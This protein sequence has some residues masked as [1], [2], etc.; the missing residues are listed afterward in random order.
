[1]NQMK[2]YLKGH[3]K[4]SPSGGDLPAGQAGLEGAELIN[5]P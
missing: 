5:Q 2:Q 3:Q 1:M 4:V